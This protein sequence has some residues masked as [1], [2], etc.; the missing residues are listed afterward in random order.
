MEMEETH[1]DGNAIGGVLEEA[2]GREMTDVR[3]RCEHCG[4]ANLVAALLV[5]RSGPGDVVRCPNCMSVVMVA[6][7]LVGGT[8]IELAGWEQP[9]A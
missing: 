3:G 8:R 6:V 4:T 5:Y 2:F 7:H 9:A 1:L